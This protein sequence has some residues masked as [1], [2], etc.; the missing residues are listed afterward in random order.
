MAVRSALV[1]LALA[2][3]LMLLSFVVPGA[4]GEVLFTL[5]AAAFPVAL[6][7]LGAARRGR[8]G[9]LALPLALLLVILVAALAGMLALRG[10]VADGPWFGGLPLAAALE[11]YGIFLLPLLL[12]GLAYALTF[13][14]HFLPDGELER[15]RARFPREPEA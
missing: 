15:L 6:I 3:P 2:P 4:W 1:F 13:D 12:V 9:P 8:L 7:A 10:R 11:L 5:L 14:R